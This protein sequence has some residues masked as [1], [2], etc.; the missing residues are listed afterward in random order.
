MSRVGT[1]QWTELYEDQPYQKMPAVKMSELGTVKYKR[2]SDIGL[3][4]LSLLFLP[5]S[6]IQHVLNWVCDRTN[7]RTEQQCQLN[8]ICLEGAKAVQ[9]SEHLSHCSGTRTGFPRRS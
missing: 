5:R 4:G 8:Q 2:A 6:E 3:P 7:N 9:L 1:I